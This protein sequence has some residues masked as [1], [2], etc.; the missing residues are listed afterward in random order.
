MT[1]EEQ[2]MQSADNI[3]DAILGCIN[4][5]QK[6]KDN[7]YEGEWCKC[8]DDLVDGLFD[9]MGDI[10]GHLRE[11]VEDANVVEYERLTGHEYGVKLGKM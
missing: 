5:L 11:G 7:N 6:E 4:V 8:I 9:G 1:E 3:R 2:R 10:C